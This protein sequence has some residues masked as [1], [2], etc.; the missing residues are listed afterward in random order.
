MPTCIKIKKGISCKKKNPQEN[1]IKHFNILNTN[2]LN[3]C[4]KLPYTEI[5]YPWVS[6]NLG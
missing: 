6:N 1:A 5:I 4:N 3:I 2:T